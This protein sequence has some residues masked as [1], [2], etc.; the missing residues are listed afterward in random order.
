[1]KSRIIAVLGIIVLAVTTTIVW[2]LDEGEKWLINP[3]RD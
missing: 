1:M 3:P 2:L